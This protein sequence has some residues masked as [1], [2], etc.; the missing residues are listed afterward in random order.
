MTKTRYFSTRETPAA[1]WMTAAAGALIVFATLGVLLY[2][3]TFGVH[4]LPA[5]RVQVVTVSE[6]GDA[7]RVEVRVS[8]DGG[9]TAAD[10]MVQG[11][12]LANERVVDRA[13]A[14]IDYV[15]GRSW[16]MAAL[17]FS[18]DPAVSRLDVRAVG[19]RVP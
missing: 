2:E 9:A 4:S 3:A 1:E 14:T 18:H 7:F 11:E 5:L 12:L 6:A 15:A 19:Y 13:E 17:L 16:E 8:N 10:V